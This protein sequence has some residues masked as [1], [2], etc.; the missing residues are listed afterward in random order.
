MWAVISFSLQCDPHFGSSPPYTD[1]HLRSTL[2]QEG[3]R[4]SHR[5][6]TYFRS[7]PPRSYVHPLAA[8]L[9]GSRYPLWAPYYRNRNTLCSSHPAHQQSVSGCSHQYSSNPLTAGESAS[10]TTWLGL[11]FRFLFVHPNEYPWL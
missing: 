3:I 8:P 5:R 7:H 1:G 6:I 9:L 2:S 4:L 11:N 10:R